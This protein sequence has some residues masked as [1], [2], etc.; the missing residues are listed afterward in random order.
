MFG[1]MLRWDI[2]LVVYMS[3]LD[4]WIRR[5]G[6][7]YDLR[8]V[9]SLV[10]SSLFTMVVLTEQ[11]NVILVT[12]T[13]PVNTDRWLGGGFWVYIYSNSAMHWKVW[14][15]CMDLRCNLDGISNCFKEFINKSNFKCCSIVLKYNVATSFSSLG[16][17]YSG[18]IDTCSIHKFESMHMS[19][20]R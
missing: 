20:F 2:M 8:T 13:S 11:Y 7:R 14:E 1:D 19:T 10:R 6:L 5:L 4:R 16:K 9:F 15:H 18:N 3:V 12:T 17:E